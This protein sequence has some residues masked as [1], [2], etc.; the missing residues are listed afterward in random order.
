MILGGGPGIPSLPSPQTPLPT[1]V[2]AVEVGACGLD[3]HGQKKNLRDWGWGFGGGA[4]GPWPLA[5][6]PISPKEYAIAEI[7]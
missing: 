1:R 3:F 7:F 4:K 5:P 6:P 2:R